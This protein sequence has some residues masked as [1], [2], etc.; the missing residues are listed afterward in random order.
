MQTDASPFAIAA[1]APIP[2]LVTPGHVLTV[3]LAIGFVGALVLACGIFRAFR[4]VNRKRKALDEANRQLLH[5]SRHDSLTGL[6]ERG[7]FRERFEE[8]LSEVHGGSRPGIALMLI[9]LDFFKKIND[10]HGHRAGDAVLVD[11]ARRFR[12]VV[13]PANIV[14]RLGGDEFAVIVADAADDAAAKKLA[15]RLIARVKMPFVVNAEELC[16]GASIGIVIAAAGAPGASALTSNADLALYEAKRRGRGTSVVYRP[17]MRAAIEERELLEGD[18]SLALQHGQLG[19]CYQPIVGAGDEGIVCREA[20]VRWHHPVR[21][22]LYPDLFIPLAESR[23]IIQQ[24]GAWVLR[25][26]CTEAAR[27][28]DTIC[29]SLNISTVQLLDPAFLKSVVEALASSGLPADRLMLEFDETIFAGIDDNLFALLQSL[30]V[31]GV[32]LV[33]D[34]FGR[35]SSSLSY[36]ER[37]NLSAV[38]I[39]REFVQAAS[40]GSPRSAAIVDAIVSLARSLDLTVTAEGV[41][42][43][44]HADAMRAAGCTHLQGYHFGRPE[45]IGGAADPRVQVA[46]RAR[47]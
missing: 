27:W 42:T 28:D 24:I 45:A 34:H 13:G 38:K 35:G 6:V 19:L 18:L 22:L 5:A 10:A 32:K 29:L 47:R 17:E 12:E 40:A 41:E 43:A 26:A 7:H 1:S 33:L 37:L 30:H 15:D 23:Q 20:L 39:H 2:E 9:D 4:E 31:L 14:G 8:L 25:E 46:Q 36:L 16:I 11:V 3:M 44:Q 21:G